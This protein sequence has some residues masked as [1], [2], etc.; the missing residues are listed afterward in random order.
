[1]ENTDLRKDQG[2][3]DRDNVTSTPLQKT[4]KKKH[5]STIT[6]GRARRP[7]RGVSVRFETHDDFRE[8]ISCTMSVSLQFERS[9]IFTQC[10]LTKVTLCTTPS[11]AWLVV[12]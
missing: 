5:G 9:P 1:M 3:G 6:Q 7:G 12:I 10:P 4:K 8:G 2:V 11:F